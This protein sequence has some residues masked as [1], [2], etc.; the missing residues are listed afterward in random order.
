[1]HVT[2]GFSLSSDWLKKSQSNLS[3]QSQ[4]MFETLN[5]I[6]EVSARRLKYVCEQ[7]TYGFGMTLKLCFKTSALNLLSPGRPEYDFYAKT[8]IS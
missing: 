8:E 7:V 1:M 6:P 4:Q 3:S 5:Q 2:I